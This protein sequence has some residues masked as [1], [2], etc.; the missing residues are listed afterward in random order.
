MSNNNGKGKKFNYKNITDATRFVR[1][2]VSYEQYEHIYDVV[3]ILIRAGGILTPAEEKELD[4][5][6]ILVEQYE[7][8]NNL[9]NNLLLNDLNEEDYDGL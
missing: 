9:L 6:I 7:E 4:R 2:I 3:S 5:L 8:D 1:S